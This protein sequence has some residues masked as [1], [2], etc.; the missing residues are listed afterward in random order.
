[1]QPRRVFTLTALTCSITCWLLYGLSCLEGPRLSPTSQ[2]DASSS[3]YVASWVY[4]EDKIIATANNNMPPNASG[5]PAP[6][7]VRLARSKMFLTANSNSNKAN[8]YYRRNVTATRKLPQALIIGVKK[9]GTRALLEF[10]RLHP[11]VRAV[12]PE[13]HFFDRHYDRGLDWYR[14]QMP[15]TLEGQLTME[16]TPSY[17]ITREVPSRIHN[18][19]RDTKLLVVVR[20]PVT[21]AISDYAQTASKRRDMRSFDELAFLNATTGLV[22]TTWGAIKIGVYAKHLD[23]WLQ[24]FALDRLHFVSGENLIKDPAGEMARVQDFLGLR[25]VI[26]ENHFYFNET[27]GFPCL[28]K[29]EGNG[30]PRCLGKTKGRVH[31][32]IDGATIQRLRDFYRP[33]NVKFYQM[34]NIDFGWP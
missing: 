18:M 23:R 29:S 17:F 9:G 19:S 1:M 3:S 16:K 13:T 14:R 33:F 31:P 32:A 4:Y 11:D 24:Y 30:G 20:D 12:G 10:L 15:P 21:R 8:V 28:K 7:P 2:A 6:H 34:T 5:N 22:D 26:T 25:R 27:K